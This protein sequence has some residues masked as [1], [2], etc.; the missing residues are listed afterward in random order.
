MR[1]IAP[2]TKW[3]TIQGDHSQRDPRG[4]STRS[5][6]RPIR[7]HGDGR[8]PVGRTPLHRHVAAGEPG[9]ALQELLI[10]GGNTVDP[11]LRD[12]IGTL[13][14]TFGGSGA[15]SLDP[16]FYDWIAQTDDGK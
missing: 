2:R 11:I 10:E 8:Q 4:I 1:H 9:A 15:P 13:R 3:P 6:H 5:E 7:L 16:Q 12:A 14:K